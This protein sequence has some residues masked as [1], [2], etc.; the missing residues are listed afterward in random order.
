MRDTMLISFSIGPCHILYRPVLATNG[1]IFG[2]L[3]IV[4]YVIP[5]IDSAR[6]RFLLHLESTA[7]ATQFDDK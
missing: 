4:S 2:R 6:I 5:L 3:C 1:I 7:S